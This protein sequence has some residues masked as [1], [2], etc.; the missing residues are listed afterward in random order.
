[1]QISESLGLGVEVHI[2]DGLQSKCLVS[3]GAIED[4]VVSIGAGRIGFSLGQ[5]GLEYFVLDVIFRIETCLSASV[6][7]QAEVLDQRQLATKAALPNYCLQVLR[8]EGGSEDQ[9]QGHKQN[10]VHFLI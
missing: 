1:M 7:A 8:L 10:P 6:V 2:E 3:V 9:Q 4:W 5:S